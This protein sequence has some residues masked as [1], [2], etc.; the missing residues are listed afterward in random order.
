M[1]EDNEPDDTSLA[2]A[3]CRGDFWNQFEEA[4]RKCGGN[5]AHIFGTFSSVWA[6]DKRVLQPYKDWSL[7]A[8]CDLLAQNGVRLTFDPKWHI[9]PEIFTDP[10]KGSITTTERTK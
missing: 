5:P 10:P 1:E 2:V 4:L 8:I 6:G 9:H 3:V 7:Q